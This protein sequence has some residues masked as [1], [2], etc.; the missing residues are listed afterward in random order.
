[1]SKYYGEYTKKKIR[2]LARKKINSINYVL[3]GGFFLLD[4]LIFCFF[5]VYLVYSIWIKSFVSPCQTLKNRTTCVAA[6]C[7]F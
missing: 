3:L 4:L 7:L 1:M 5:S 2:A 6:V